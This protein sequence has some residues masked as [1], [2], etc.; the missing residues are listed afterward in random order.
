MQ[1]HTVVWHETLSCM[2]GSQLQLLVLKLSQLLMPGQVQVQV[3]APVLEVVGVEQVPQMMAVV[4]G[5]DKTRNTFVASAH[6]F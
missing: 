4:C 1:S 3:Q 6:C 2:C 5:D